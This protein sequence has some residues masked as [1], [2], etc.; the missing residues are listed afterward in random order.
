MFYP[1]LSDPDMQA[2]LNSIAIVPSM[3]GDWF[4]VSEDGVL[5]VQLD[6]IEGF[7]WET[8]GI[9][10]SSPEE[11]TPEPEVETEESS[12]NGVYTLTLRDTT[13]GWFTQ[14][15][16]LGSET[17]SA[18]QADITVLVSGRK[19]IMVTKAEKE[20]YDEP[21]EFDFTEFIPATGEDYVGT[22]FDETSQRAT[23][24][25]TDLGND[26]YEMLLSWGSSASEATEW[27]M[28]GALDG[29]GD[30]AYAGG[31]KA[32]VVY[33]ENGEIVSEE[34]VYTDGEGWFSVAEGGLVW[35]DFQEETCA[36]FFFVRGE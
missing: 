36:D 20:I 24:E 28:S 33:G 26:Q 27:R 29:V 14:Y 5:T 11:D 25:I 17:A 18:G 16:S 4:S 21:Q 7:H 13:D 1:H 22:W 9:A 12:E 15:L 19:I 2:V 31:T 3:T 6:E 34:A 23:L 30:L 32:H 8:A 35:T 10:Y